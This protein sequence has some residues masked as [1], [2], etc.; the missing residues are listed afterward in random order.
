MAK[1]KFG[2]KLIVS[3]FLS[4]PNV[5]YHSF[6]LTFPLFN[7]VT[8]NYGH[9]PIWSVFSIIGE[10]LFYVWRIPHHGTQSPKCQTCFFPN[11]LCSLAQVMW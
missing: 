9:C 2:Q 10:I 7:L 8:H 4:S 1:M 3:S 11:L 6:L 5:L